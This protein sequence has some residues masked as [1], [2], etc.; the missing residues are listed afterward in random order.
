MNP[1]VSYNSP[2]PWV[3]YS[4]G[5]YY[6]TRTTGSDVRVFRATTLPGIATATPVV[7]F[8]P[9][10][11][12]LNN[13]WAPELHYL[14]GN[15][16]IYTCGNTNT[17]GNSMRMFVL[18]ADTQ[19]PQGSYTYKGLLDRA[20]P[21]IDDTVLVRDADNAK[22][23]VWSHSDGAGQSLYIG[24]LTNA[25]S[26]GS[27]R[28]RISTPTYAWEKHGNVN[29]G[30]EILKRNGK[31][32][33]IYSASATST[34]D[35]CLGLLVN[36]DGNY[37]NAASWTKFS[38]PVFQRSPANGTYCVGHCSFTQSPSGAEDWLV[39]H[40]TSDPT[41]SQTGK[42]LMRIQR[43]WW[44]SDDTPNFDVPT[45][46]GIYL[47]APDEAPGRPA[48]GLRGEYFTNTTLTGASTLTTNYTM[49]FDW[50]TGAPLPSLGTDSF[51]VRWTGR[52]YA[53]V[54]GTYLFQTVS[55]NGARFWVNGQLLI[56]DWNVH[57]ATTNTAAITLV[58]GEFHD[59]RFEYFDSTSPA[60]ASLRWLPPGG[61]QMAVIPGASLYPSVNGLCGESFATTNLSNRIAVRLDPVVDF[62]W[63]TGFAA[64]GMPP[65]RFGAR[66]TGQVQPLYTEAYTFYVSSSNG[67]R[68]WVNNQLLIDQWIDD[69]GTEYSG[70]INLVAGQKY[71][72]KLECFNNVGAA[73]CHLSWFSTRQPKEIIPTAHLFP[74]Y[75]QLPVLANPPDQTILAGR[76]LFVTNS[77]TDPDLPPQTLT[78]SL[79]NPP[80][81]ASI[82]AS[83]GLLIWRPTLAQSPSTN[84]LRLAVADSGTP[85]Q[86][87]TQAFT[88]T[89]LRPAPPAL[90]DMACENG[91]FSFLVSGDSG[92]D[93]FIESATNLP[94]SNWLTLFTTN[95]PQ[96]PFQ[97]SAP[98]ANAP[99]QFFRVRLAP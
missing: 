42:R 47:L 24:P 27:L 50:G 69:S 63:G 51:S 90:D 39:Y 86:S 3:I 54:S 70:T 94:A 77:A 4:N 66:W 82:N 12:I 31:T 75:N 40:G 83:N 61:S 13:I 10:G 53:P 18:Q 85:S 20:L 93:Y 21:A 14:D 5:Y 97:W 64:L 9:N 35:H 65:D 11:E 44:N 95:S 62:D 78:F 15:W 98:A 84:L 45:P 76:T 55:G 23:L 73:A 80:T 33:I 87:A 67:R 1:L 16:Y 74:P 91:A 52:V 6:H 25:W 72:L 99:Q 71:D 17:A 88:V 56:N 7:V 41:G 59:L 22:F 96:L 36:T 89:V 28:V 29:E 60:M 81:G 30:P 26:L 43:F 79:L 37:T 58:G 34:E 38:N 48:Q 68:L 46:A 92:P 57:S 49:D 2:D 19:D 32:F 8:R